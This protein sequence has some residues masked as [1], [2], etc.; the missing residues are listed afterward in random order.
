MPGPG[1]GIQLITGRLLLQTWNRTALGKIDKEG[2]FISTALEK[3]RYGVSTIYSDNHGKTWHFGSSF[4][5]NIHMNE[6]CIV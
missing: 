1:H 2:K 4:G 5:E 3:R 6:S